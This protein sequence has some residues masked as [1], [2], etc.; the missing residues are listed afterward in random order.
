MSGNTLDELSWV[1]GNG[2]QAAVVLSKFTGDSKQQPV[3]KPMISQ[4]FLGSH[5]KIVIASAL[6]G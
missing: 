6:L 4:S 3:W 1:Y 5:I 2:T